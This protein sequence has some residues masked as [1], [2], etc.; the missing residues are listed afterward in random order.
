MYP[1]SD[2]FSPRYYFYHYLSHHYL[3]Y[4]L[5]LEFPKQPQMQSGCLYKAWLIHCNQRPNPQLNFGWGF[6]TQGRLLAFIY[7]KKTYIELSL[8]R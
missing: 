7:S 6:L 1:E 5:L 8:D 2:Q 3:K 4:G